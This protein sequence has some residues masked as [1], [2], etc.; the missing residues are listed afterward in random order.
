M[1]NLAG[2]IP[3]SLINRQTVSNHASLP[4]IALFASM[5]SAVL[6]TRFAMLV[7]SGHDV[8]VI[9]VMPHVPDVIR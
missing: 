2:G 1:S 5:G 3:V 8:A 7:D 9:A 6:V 4:E